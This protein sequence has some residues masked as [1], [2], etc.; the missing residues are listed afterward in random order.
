MIVTTL[1]DHPKYYGIP[2]GWCL[3]FYDTPSTP[4]LVMQQR[5]GG[6]VGH[7]SRPEDLPSGLQPG[8]PLHAVQRNRRRVEREHV[9]YTHEYW[10]GEYPAHEALS[11]DTRNNF[12]V[13]RRK[14]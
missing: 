3:F 11:Q 5:H 6:W 1:P 10:H 14:T 7:T 2:S 12:I 4:V 9:S 13:Q 8:Q